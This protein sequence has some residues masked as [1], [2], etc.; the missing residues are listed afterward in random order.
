MRV[1]LV[2]TGV[3][4]IPPVGYGGVERTIDEYAHA[5]RSAGHE[6]T[7]VNRI[8]HGR[9]VD[10]YLFALDLPSLLRDISADV[11]HASTPVVANRLAMLGLPFVYT[12]HSRHWFE[13]RGLRERFGFWLERRAVRRAAATVA[14]TDR[15]RREMEHRVRPGGSI[16]TI[17]IGV[18]T[19]RFRPDWTLRRGQ[20][21][22]GVG[23]VRPFKRW[24]LAAR[25]LQGS[26]WTFRLVGPTPD[27]EYAAGLRSLGPHVELL[28]EVPATD[29]ENEY[30][31]A[32]VLV[33][34]SRVE[35]LAGAVL[36]GLSAGLPVLG[37]DP[38]SA[39]LTQGET[40][41]TAPESASPSEVEQ[42][43]RGKLDELRR[44]PGTLRRM[45]E[46]A[47]R[48]AQERFAWPRVV[49]QHVALYKSLA[50]PGELTRRSGPGT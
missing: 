1:L 23:V 17:P 9:S 41:W 21:A 42:F 47:R 14:L 48:S 40:G 36:Q 27:A 22:L 39:L 44:D 28:G 15:L 35:V 46:A 43:L 29:L 3:L 25:A 12:S 10:E 26:G 38:V 24:E 5:L 11:V 33:H 13:R 19:E 8:R 34:P 2:G 31:R 20:V 32:D 6:A 4:S 7:V 50:R 16:A 49:E 45:G 18:D 37:A 30:A